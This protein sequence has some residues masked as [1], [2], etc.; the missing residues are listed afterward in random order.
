[1]TRCHNCKESALEHTGTSGGGKKKGKECEIT[2]E[3]PSHFAGKQGLER[4]G[5]KRGGKKKKK[6]V[7]GVW[8]AT[9]QQI[10]VIL[11]CGERG[12]KEDVPASA[13]YYGG[14]L[15]EP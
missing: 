13:S 4:A 8:S 7:E 10:L 12:G 6:R 9:V 5:R 3:H 2:D 15:V 14:G 11:L 1:M